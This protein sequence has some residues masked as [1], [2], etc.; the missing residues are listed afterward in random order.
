MAKKKKEKAEGGQ[1]G[2][3][4]KELKIISVSVVRP[5]QVVRNPRQMGL[6]YIIDKLGPTHERTLQHIV[7]ELQT[8]YGVDFGYDFRKIGNTP[9]SP[10][11]KTDI[12]QLL[13]VGFIETEPSLYRKLRTTSTGKDAL[14]KHGAPP[15]VVE[16][17]NANFEA[18]RNKTSMLDEQLDLEI[19]KRMQL[20]RPRRRF[21]F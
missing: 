10:Q 12:V 14:E 6:L 5:E 18:L 21:P 20:S 1:E 17:L 13:Y 9:Y 16:T 3:G 19:R 8:E 7:Y 4:T 2:K 15:K 11:L